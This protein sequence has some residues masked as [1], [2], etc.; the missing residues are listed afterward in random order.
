MSKEKLIKYIRSTFNSAVNIDAK[1]FQ[2]GASLKLLTKPVYKIFFEP[3]KYPDY[4]QYH[5]FYKGLA[6]K[7]FSAWS[8]ATDYNISFEIV[9]KEYKADLLIFFSTSSIKAIGISYTEYLPSI[10]GS[11]KGKECISIAIRNAKNEPVNSDTIY[12]VI[13]HEIGHFFGLGHS[14]DEIDVMSQKG[15]PI[16]FSKNDLF[17]LRL[18]YSIGM[19]KPYKQVKKH[20][21]ECVKNFLDTGYIETE[22]PICLP[23]FNN[24]EFLLENSDVKTNPRNNEIIPSNENNYLATENLPENLDKIS[25]IKKYQITLQNLDIKVN[26]PTPQDN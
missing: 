6:I 16:E 3:I 13:L 8:K 2:E 17:V 7:A 18:V 21:E 26:Y 19:G 23:T 12:H 11:I 22:E 20:I 5:N 25:D 10:G 15:F 14:D 4:R 1:K 24:E 9:D